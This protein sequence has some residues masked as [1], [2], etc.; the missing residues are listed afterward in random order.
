MLKGSPGPTARAKSFD[1]TENIKACALTTQNDLATITGQKN[2]PRVSR[3]INTH[4]DDI[5]RDDRRSKNLH[6]GDVK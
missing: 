5:G 6:A 2:R 3:P 1:T 4:G